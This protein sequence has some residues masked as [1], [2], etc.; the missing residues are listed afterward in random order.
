[1]CNFFVVSRNRQHLIGMPDIETVDILTIN[2]NTIQMK[3]AESPENC[4]T[5]MSQK[6]DATEE[7]YTNTDN[8]SKFE[9]EEKPM[10]TDNG[11]NNIEYFLP[12]PNSDNDKRVRAEITK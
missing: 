10:V 6:I 4:K 3:K 2:C 11:N 1:M 7:Y 5:N 8:I 9:D 12:G